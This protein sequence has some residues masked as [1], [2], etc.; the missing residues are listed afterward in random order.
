[1]TTTELTVD[2]TLPGHREAMVLGATEQQRLIDVLRSLSADDWTKPTD[3]SLW[4]VR[5]TVAHNLG[6]LEANASLR[7]ML[8]QMRIVTKRA[9]ALGNQMV[10]EMTALQIDERASLTTAE[11]LGRIEAT[12]PRAI[13]GRRRMPSVMR[14][15]VKID[16]P[17]PFGRM[18]LGYLCDTIFT[19]DMWMHRI[20]ICRA[21]GKPLELTT[22]HDGRLVA[23]IVGEW[24]GR[25]DQDYDLV[26]DGPAGG[27]FRRGDGGVSL[28]LD[29][30]EF[31]RILSGRE[32]TSARGLLSTEVL[33]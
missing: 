10:D 14:R 7:E 1:V 16:A 22:D 15:F 24:A 17:S 26:L 23:A 11:L 13:A 3:C 6:S 30:V 5:A 9:K 20:D 18:T 8:H 28:R 31:C 4:D 12:A 33:F 19:R 21:T 29:A 2:T 27:H 32:S 25:H